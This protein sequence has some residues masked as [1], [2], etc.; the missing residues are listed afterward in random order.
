MEDSTVGDGIVSS[1]KSKKK[2]ATA[3][4]LQLF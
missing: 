2:S 3:C 4:T 1:G